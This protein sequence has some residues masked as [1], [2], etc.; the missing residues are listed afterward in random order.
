MKKFTF[1]TLFLVIINACQVEKN[2]RFSECD[3][4]TNYL[5]LRLD[6]IEVDKNV[7]YFYFTDSSEYFNNMV[8]GQILQYK[9]SELNIL[10]DQIDSVNSRFYMPN[11]EKGK[12]LDFTIS[13]EQL[14]KPLEKFNDSVFSSLISDLMTINIESSKQF[15]S[16]ET[17]LLDWMNT[18]FAGKINEKYKGK[19]PEY[20]YFFGYDSFDM[21]Y[22]YLRECD[23]EINGEATEFI[24]EINDDTYIS[25]GLKNK[26]SN[27]FNK[28]SNYK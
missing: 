2:K 22:K 20:S 3:L 7:L 1:I 24:L 26:L 5:G 9:I 4:K 15:N 17:S 6:S 23:S 19:I 14:L 10:T 28:Y 25:K 12:I 8:T 11:R 13:K 18:Y 27:L 16:P 21:L